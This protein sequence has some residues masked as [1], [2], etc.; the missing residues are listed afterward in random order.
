[1]PRLRDI[2][3]DMREIFPR[4][5]FCECRRVFILCLE[6]SSTDVEQTLM[7]HSGSGESLSL[8]SPKLETGSGTSF[9]SQL[10]CY[11]RL[12]TPTG[13]ESILETTC[14]HTTML[15][16]I[17]PTIYVR[18][19]AYGMA[20]SSKTPAFL[21]SAWGPGMFPGRSRARIPH[22][23]EARGPLSFK[24]KQRQRWQDSVR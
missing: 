21:R 4:S 16:M 17:A 14:A 23:S 20:C 11:S 24:L 9:G 18:N 6:T 7:L 15:R 12:P 19:R 22:P 2:G 13:I 10:G 3:H 5:G 8:R 1:M